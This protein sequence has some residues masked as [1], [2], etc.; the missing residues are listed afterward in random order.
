METR[1]KI[2]GAKA[3]VSETE[4]WECRVDRYA[5]EYRGDPS[6]GGCVFSIVA[7]CHTS[8]L[9]KAQDRSI[10]SVRESLRSLP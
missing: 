6:T 7:E 8:F 4:A 10:P 1:V 5:G 3:K 2:S 9:L